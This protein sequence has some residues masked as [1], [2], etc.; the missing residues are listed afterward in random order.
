MED[1]QKLWSAQLGAMPHVSGVREISSIIVEARGGHALT[2]AESDKLHIFFA[3]SLRESSGGYVCTDDLLER[4]V[5]STLLA[6][7]LRS[8][9]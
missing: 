9:S 4:L 5:G 6:S 1:F 7:L 8:A 3:E 2:S